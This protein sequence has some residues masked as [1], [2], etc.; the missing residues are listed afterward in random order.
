MFVGGIP[1]TAEAHYH[2]AYLRSISEFHSRKPNWMSELKDDTRLSQLSIPGTHNSMSKSFQRRALFV[3]VKQLS[4]GNFIYRDYQVPFNVQDG[5]LADI[6]HQNLFVG[7]KF[8]INL[9]Q[10]F[11]VGGTKNLS[12]KVTHNNSGESADFSVPIT[13]RW[14]NTIIFRGAGDCAGGALS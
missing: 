11:V 10:M 13:L 6:T 3:F 7:E 9:Y 4:T 2:P 12:V 5:I 1:V 8:D 14:G